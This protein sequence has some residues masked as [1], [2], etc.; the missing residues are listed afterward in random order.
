MS[1]VAQQQ[2][3]ILSDERDQWERLIEQAFRMGYAVGLGARNE[4]Y[5]SG[6]VDGTTYRKRAEHAV[7]ELAALEMLRWG[8]AGRARFGAPRPGDFTGRGAAW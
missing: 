8:P 1:A 2:L 3:M 5:D 4:A 7:I 6:T